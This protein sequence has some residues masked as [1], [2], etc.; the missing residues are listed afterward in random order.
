MAEYQANQYNQGQMHCPQCGAPFQAGAAFC[1]NCGAALPQS[2]PQG[3]VNQ[4]SVNQGSAQAGPVHCPNCGNLLQPG[5]KFCRNCGSPAPSQI[6]N[7]AP[8]NTAQGGYGQGPQNT[9]QGGYRQGPQNGPQGGYGGQGPRYGGTL[10]LSRAGQEIVS[11][12][13]GPVMLIFAALATLSCILQ[14]ALNFSALTVLVNIPLIVILI[15]IWMAYAMLRSNPQATGGITL[16]RGGLIAQFVIYIIVCVILLIAGIILL[17]MS[18]NSSLRYYG[19]SGVVAGIGIAIVLIGAVLLILYI[20]YFK[21]LLKML[22]GIREVLCGAARSFPSG[23]LPA[24]LIVIAIIGNVIGLIASIFIASSMNSMISGLASSIGM[25]SY[26]MSQLL[27]QYTNVGNTV[28]TVISA[29]VAAASN[30]FG[31][32][33]YLNAKSISEKSGGGH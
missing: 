13:S 10:S 18:G 24:V 16:I 17:V 11:L 12:A 30:V 9:P 28:L 15:G 7:A 1:R 26:Q 21:T 22:K 14:L 32:L 29:L 27:S 19:G 33:L 23:I 8:Q 4:G 20:F 2:R 25:S 6:A 31:L 3:G 5:M